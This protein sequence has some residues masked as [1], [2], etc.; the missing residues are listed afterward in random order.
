[1]KW[2]TPSATD[3]LSELFCFFQT[4]PVRAQHAQLSEALI[5][6]SKVNEPSS[7][8]YSTSLRRSPDLENCQKK[9][10]PLNDPE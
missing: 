10:P 5:M 9:T 1:M 7:P 3:I 6:H 8:E 4:Q 2:Q